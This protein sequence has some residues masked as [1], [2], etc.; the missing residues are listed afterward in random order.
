MMIIITDF[1]NNNYICY[2][3]D[4]ISI[5]LNDDNYNIFK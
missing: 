3:Q 4:K 5:D 1:S 2:F